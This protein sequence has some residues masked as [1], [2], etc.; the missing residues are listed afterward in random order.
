VQKPDQTA[1]AAVG[2]DVPRN[3]CPRRGL[4]N[5]CGQR[6][7]GRGA[8][9]ATLMVPE[10]GVAPTTFDSTSDLNTN[11]GSYTESLKQL[12]ETS[13]SNWPTSS[14]EPPS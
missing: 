12:K 4:N 9:W 1:G 14:P 5:G 7:R 3:S 10:A 6:D 2:V 11:L 8:T 13:L